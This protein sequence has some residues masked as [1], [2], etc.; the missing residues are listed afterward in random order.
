MALEPAERGPRLDLS[1]IIVSWNV[2]PLLAACL[3]SIA[4]APVARAAPD[5]S[6]AGD[7]GP[8]VEVIVVDSASADGSAEMVR[9]R[10]SWVHLLA[11]QQNIGFTRGNNLGL[12]RARGRHLMLLNPD[13]VVHGDA[14]NRLVEALDARPAVGIVGPR[15][16][17]ADGTTQSTRRRFPTL[18][19]AFFESTWLQGCAPRGVIERFTVADQPDDGV[20][21]VDWVQGC[22]L[23]ARR[24]VY[25]Q[26]G[27]LDTGYVMF[28]EELDWC[29]RA[30]DAGWRVLYLGTATI[31]HYGGKSTEQIE[32]QK[33]IYFQASKIRYFRKFHGRVV[34]LALRLFLVL[35]YAAQ[36]AL[37]A[38]KGLLGHKRDLRRAR[39]ATYRRVVVALATGR[40]GPA[41]PR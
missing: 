38:L 9:A 36:W 8:L 7:G 17:N 26:I 32:T 3:D 12:A 25:Q 24:E 30:K 33:H 13:T 35:S 15:V 23:A 6:R 4:A 19:T 28:S 29:R 41:Q 10:Y 11:E 18:A 37:E 31:T 22:A 21:E 20:F 34:A 27:G 2:A 1:I 40:T 5:G 14:L 39:V 16:L